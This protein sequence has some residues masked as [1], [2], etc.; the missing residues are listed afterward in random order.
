LTVTKHC[1]PRTDATQR[2]M[3]FIVPPVRERGVSRNLDAMRLRLFSLYGR[4]REFVERYR[5]VTVWRIS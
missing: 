5:S 4:W 1:S 3:M 2:L